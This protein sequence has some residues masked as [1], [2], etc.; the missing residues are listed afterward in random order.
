MIKNWRTEISPRF[1]CISMLLIISA[2]KPHLWR[3]QQNYQK[4]SMVRCRRFTFAVLI[5]RQSWH[6]WEATFSQY[7]FWLTKSISLASQIWPLVLLCGCNSRTDR[8]MR[9]DS[10]AYRAWHW[11]CEEEDWLQL[12]SNASW[13]LSESYL[14]LQ[15]HFV[16]CHW[17]Y[18]HPV[19]YQPQYSYHWSSWHWFMG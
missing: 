18:L 2:T 5:L 4:K 14:A 9:W 11:G 19:P 12:P 15:T 10:T 17:Q 3:W 16:A 6:R 1:T 8:E 7:Y 13:I